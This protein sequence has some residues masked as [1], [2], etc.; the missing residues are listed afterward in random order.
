MIG[1]NSIFNQSNIYLDFIAGSS[2]K[3]EHTQIRL[4]WFSW[5]ITGVYIVILMLWS[6]VHPEYFR[7]IEGLALIPGILIVVFV[8]IA[9]G[10]LHD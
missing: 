5:I 1:I 2:M 10:W 7:E 3:N 9:S 8:L 4:K 6:I